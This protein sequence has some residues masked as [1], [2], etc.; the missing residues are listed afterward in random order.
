M[1]ELVKYIKSLGTPNRDIIFVS[2]N[3][4]E[5]GCLGSKAFVDKYYSKIKILHY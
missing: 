3:A 4:E 2:F 5:F 1:L